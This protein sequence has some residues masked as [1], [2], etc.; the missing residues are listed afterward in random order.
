MKKIALLCGIVLAG[1][2]AALVVGLRAA[3]K[4]D[5]PGFFGLGTLIADVNITLEVL[6]VLGLT[7][8]MGL[9]PSRRIASI[10]L[11]GSW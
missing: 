3:G 2:A 4:A 8:G 10:R 1:A 7:V 5:M 9:A 6:L 11:H